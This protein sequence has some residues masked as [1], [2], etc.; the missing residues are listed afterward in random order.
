VTTKNLNRTRL[1]ALRAFSHLRVVL[2]CVRASLRANPRV[3]R[4][5]V[6][7]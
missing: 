1:R 4:F 6:P 5:C 3:I 2:R 7:C